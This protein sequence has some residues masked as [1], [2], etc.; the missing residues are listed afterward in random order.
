MSLSALQAHIQSGRGELRKG[1]KTVLALLHTAKLPVT[2][3]I[4]ALLVEGSLLES[5]LQA[6]PLAHALLPEIVPSTF[7]F[8][9][10]DFFN[11]E[12]T[13]AVH[14]S[15]LSASCHLLHA[16]VYRQVVR[17]CLPCRVPS[18]TSMLCAQLAAWPTQYQT[19]C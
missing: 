3:R 12:A 9:E 2:R 8:Q 1:L 5:D 16:A 17:L 4:R 19:V 7:T 10:A 13:Q 15:D 6:N 18:P 14:A 11:T